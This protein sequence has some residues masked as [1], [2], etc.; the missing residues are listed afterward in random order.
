MKGKEERKDYTHLNSE[1]QRIEW[2]DKKA[3]LSDPCKEREENNGMGKTRD[4]FKKFRDTKGLF[5]AKM[6]TMKNRNSMHLTEAEDMRRGSKNAEK[7]Y[8][9]N[10]LNDPDNY[11]GVVIHLEARHPRV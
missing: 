2:R 5:H 3:F 1:F 4:L 6:D 7:N 8:T 9:K 11:D 10:D